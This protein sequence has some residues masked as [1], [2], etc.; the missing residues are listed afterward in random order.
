MVPG[1]CSSGLA[2]ELGKSNTAGFSGVE[3]SASSEVG[4]GQPAGGLGRSLW[5]SVAITYVARLIG[6]LL[7]IG[8]TVLTAR[9]LGPEGRG[10]IASGLALTTLG[11]NLGCLGIPAANAFFSA[12]KPELVGALTGN[13]VLIALLSGGL[14]SVGLGAARWWMPSVIPLPGVFLLLTCL[15]VVGQLA[16]ASLQ[17]IL[18]GTNRILEYNAQEVALRFVVLIGLLVLFWVEAVSPGK[19]YAVL[20]LATCAV[21]LWSLYSCSRMRGLSI[22]LDLV[23]QCAGYSVTVYGLTLLNVALQNVDVLFVQHFRGPFDTG[24]YNVAICIRN[25]LMLFYVVA[26]GLIM[27]RLSAVAGFRRRCAYVAKAAVGIG[28]INLLLIACAWLVVGWVV[29]VFFGAEFALSAEIVVALFPGVL[30][31]GWL[32][33]V[34]CLFSA[35][36][37][38][39]AMLIPGTTGL[40]VNCCLLYW[41]V[42]QYGPVGAAWAFSAACA[43]A[44]LA[45]LGVVARFWA[46]CDRQLE[47]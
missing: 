32:G 36:N 30:F 27:P 3:G 2:E 19:A 25:G 40:V 7:A 34:D 23:R 26:V 37:A 29:E 10:Y 35:S 11:C 38:P 45:G 41:W 18:V 46:R 24:L 6:V 9:L 22:S 17:Q 21:A 8:Y 16:Y 47:C 13:T 39:I 31:V 33:C 43:V 42:P 4:R 44:W 1:N 15:M 14:V 12:R 20:A 5:R 28:T